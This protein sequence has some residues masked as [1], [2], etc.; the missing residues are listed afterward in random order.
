MAGDVS[1]VKIESRMGQPLSGPNTSSLVSAAL[2]FQLAR[3][4]V[5][6]VVLAVVV[7]VVSPK[8]VRE[9]LLPFWQWVLLGIGFWGSLFS[10]LGY[11]N[12]GGRL[13]LWELFAAMMVRL[14]P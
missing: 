5:I 1:I 8:D 7:A 10:V 6:I 9:P 2:Y 11:H 4:F 14:T 13:A 3:A 12:A